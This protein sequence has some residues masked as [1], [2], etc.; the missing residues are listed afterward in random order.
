MSQTTSNGILKV[1]NYP[2]WQVLAIESIDKF[3]DIIWNEISQWIII[4]NKTAYFFV[5][6]TKY[7]NMLSISKVVEQYCFEIDILILACLTSS[8]AIKL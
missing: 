4:Q 2:L 1:Y 3:I 5:S 6:Y 7:Q 8:I